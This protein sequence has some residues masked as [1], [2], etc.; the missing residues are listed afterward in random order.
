MGELYARARAADDGVFDLD[1]GNLQ[2]L[3]R[4]VRREAR[5]LTWR[6]AMQRRAITVSAVLSRLAGAVQGDD[7]ARTKVGGG[8]LIS[9]TGVPVIA[10]T[11]ATP[12]RTLAELAEPLTIRVLRADRVDIEKL[13]AVEREGV[14]SV[15]DEQP[16]AT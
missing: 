3:T 14:A 11:T 7:V 8:W 1:L 12:G 6:A 15:V 5:R 16:E 2:A 10:L 13:Q 9:A 4:Q